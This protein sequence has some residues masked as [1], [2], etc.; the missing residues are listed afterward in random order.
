MGAFL[1]NYTLENIKIK[2]IV[3]YVLNVTDIIFTLLLWN[4]GLFTEV[5]IIMAGILN[6]YMVS[7]LTKLGLPAALLSVVFVRM[8]RAS[9]MQLKQSNYII[10]AVLV[11][12]SFI[13]ILHILWCILLPINILYTTYTLKP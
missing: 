5:N 13:N 8:R 9:E 4:T 1:R 12:Y 6:N 11:F 2:F 10:L 3:L 7:L